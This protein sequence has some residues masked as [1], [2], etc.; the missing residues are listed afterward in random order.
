MVL[1]TEKAGAP[2]VHETNIK[3]KSTATAA[4]RPGSDVGSATSYANYI[5]FLCLTWASEIKVLSY[6]NESVNIGDGLKTVFEFGRHS[7]S[8]RLATGYKKRNIHLLNSKFVFGSFYSLHFNK[9]QWFQE[10]WNDRTDRNVYFTDMQKAQRAELSKVTQLFNGRFKTRLPGSRPFSTVSHFFPEEGVQDQESPIR[11]VI[12]PRV[13]VTPN[14][15]F[16]W[17][18]HSF[19]PSFIHS[20][21]TELVYP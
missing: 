9:Y 2:F 13:F 4:R 7:V 5:A 17:F 21:G 16:N 1:R 20:P 8:Q 19:F 14:T 15:V 12:I 3:M 11:A 6:R 18:T 10:S